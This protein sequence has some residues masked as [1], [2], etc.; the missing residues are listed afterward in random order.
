[1]KL[2]LADRRSLQT[3]SSYP[4]M[5][6][7]VSWA[8]LGRRGERAHVETDYLGHFCSCGPENTRFVLAVQVKGGQRHLGPSFLV[9]T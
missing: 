1:M 3:T 2:P 5:E 8:T 6:E 9:S 4:P 7:R